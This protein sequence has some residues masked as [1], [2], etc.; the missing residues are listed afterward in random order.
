MFIY[1]YIY[2]LLSSRLLT[3]SEGLTAMELYVP[4]TY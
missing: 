2:T 4:Y 1:L 3:S